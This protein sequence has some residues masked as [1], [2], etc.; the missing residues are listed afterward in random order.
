MVRLVG[1]HRLLAFG[2]LARNLQGDLPA[3]QPGLARL[4]DPYEI[5]PAKVK[6]DGRALQGYRTEHLADAWTRYL[7][8]IAPEPEPAE[9]RPP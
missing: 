5:T 4:L 3:G 2:A 9:P 8:G 1:L 7:P 6:I